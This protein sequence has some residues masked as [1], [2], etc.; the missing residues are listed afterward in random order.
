[1]FRVPS[2]ATPLGSPEAEGHELSRVPSLER[3]ST[4]A[5]LRAFQISPAGET[6]T[7]RLCTTVPFDRALPTA[8]SPVVIRT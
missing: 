3:R 8:G 5:L 1:M 4:Q 7:P 6:L 2:K